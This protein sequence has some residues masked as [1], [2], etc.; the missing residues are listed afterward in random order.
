MER[1]RLAYL[2]DRVGEGD[3]GAHQELLDHIMRQPEGIRV[4]ALEALQEG[5]EDT[6]EQLMLTLADDP[7]LTIR[8]GP[9]PTE[10]KAAL[11]SQPRS[12]PSAPVGAH[13]PQALRDTLRS[14]E[15]AARVQAAR[16]LG[17]YTDLETI[18]ALLGAIR[19]GD[20]Q[21]AAAAVEALQAIG[22]PAIP[23]LMD[24]LR[25]QDDQVRWHSAKTLSTVATTSAVE[26]LLDA[27]DDNN[28]GVRWLAAEGLVHAGQAAIAPLLRRL[29]ETK[30][31]AW[32]RQGAWHVLNKANVS[33]EEARQHYKELASRI[34]RSSAATFPDLAR[35]ELRRLGED[36]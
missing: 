32:L 30:A 16:Q 17:G 18:A 3:V 21:V 9:R 14:G 22:S 26:G 28:Y 7:H 34:K 29:A 6:Y 12:E 31:S 20:K 15:R 1:E 24:A 13:G 25:D 35:Q 10:G 27:L 4:L 2:L 19:A 23:A 36:A 8:S 33:G 11:A 5:G